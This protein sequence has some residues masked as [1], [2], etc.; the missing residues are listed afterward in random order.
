MAVPGQS[1]TDD[2]IDMLASQA[3][4]R[5]VSAAAYFASRARWRRPAIAALLAD[6]CPD[7]RCQH[8]R[9]SAEVE[10]LDTFDWRV[11][12][13]S[14]VVE[15]VAHGADRVLLLRALAEPPRR[16]PQP[17]P[18]GIVRPAE[19]GGRFMRDEL[20][21]LCGVR[22]LLPVA[23]LR[24]REDLFTLLDAD[25]APHLQVGLRVE[26]ADGQRPRQRLVLAP[27]RGHAECA[28][29]VRRALVA[30]GFEAAPDPLTEAL[31]DAGREPFDYPPPEPL[32]LHPRMPAREAFACIG[33]R[34]LDIM[35]RNLG[36]LEADIDSEFLHD[37]RVALRRTRTLL[38]QVREVLPSARVRRFKSAFRWLGTVSGAARDGDVQLA[39]IEELVAA[40]PVATREALTPLL[41]WMHAQREQARTTLLRA[42]SGARFRRLCADWRAL[43]EQAP[44]RT[45]LR[46]AAVP[47][48]ELAGER[49][50]AVFGH[51]LRKGARIDD[52]SPPAELHELRKIAKKLRYL[53]E[54]FRPLYDPERVDVLVRDLKLLQENLGAYQDLDV[55]RRL[56]ED[57]APHAPARTVAV[58]DRLAASMRQRE[59]QV[60][61]EFAGRFRAFSSARVA[62]HLHAMLREVNMPPDR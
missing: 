33:L 38:A 23:T 1:V 42:L 15:R 59:A 36:G 60:R 13:A 17:V 50:R 34:L 44:T 58:L 40:E 51:L 54:F 49:V 12:R 29:R 55:Q 26:Q 22:A 6:V 41:A 52:S 21:R 14:R 18:P 62:R 28:R 46:N 25:G 31:R 32:T 43:L 10:Y 5:K 16:A 27:V 19:L 7:L 2:D 24:R 4:P 37:F 39:E 57:F 9:A 3:M 56:L 11:L 8:H 20:L 47:I 61:A 30:A 35:E 45:R 53:I 48:A